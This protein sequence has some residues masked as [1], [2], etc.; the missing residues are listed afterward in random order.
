MATFDKM[1]QLYDMQKKAKAVQKD[2]KDTEIE[3]KSG[4]GLVTVVFTADQKLTEL[5]IDPSLLKSENKKDLET[6]LIRTFTEGMQRAQA[7]AAEK[8]KEIMKEM[9]INLPGM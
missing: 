2:L 3:V 1:K 8:T 6:K 7:I 9:N 4:D 5:N